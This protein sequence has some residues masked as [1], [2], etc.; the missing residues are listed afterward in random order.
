MKFVQDELRQKNGDLELQM[1]EQGFELRRAQAQLRSL[2]R[3]RAFKKGVVSTSRQREERPPAPRGGGGRGGQGRRGAAAEAPRPGGE[4]TVSRRRPLEAPRA[5]KGSERRRLKGKLEDAA[6]DALVAIHRRSDLTPGTKRHTLAEVLQRMARSQAEAELLGDARRVRESILNASLDGVNCDPPTPPRPSAA[7]GAAGGT[8]GGGRPAPGARDPP[9]S[10]SPSGGG[11]GAAAATTPPRGQAVGGGAA[12]RQALPAPRPP[13]AV[14]EASRDPARR[15][16]R[17]GWN[18]D[19]KAPAPKKE[20]AMEQTERR[21]RLAQKALAAAI[22]AAPPQA[23]RRSRSASPAVASPPPPSDPPSGAER[24]W[25]RPRAAAGAAGATGPAPGRKRPLRRAGPRGEAGG[26][27]W[28]PEPRAGEWR[29][30]TDHQAESDVE[31]AI[32]AAEARLQRFTEGLIA[33]L[34]VHLAAH[35]PHG[36]PGAPAGAAPGLVPGRPSMPP[37]PEP[38]RAVGLAVA[39][40]EHS[41]GRATPPGRHPGPASGVVAAGGGGLRAGAGQAP[42]VVLS[43]AEEPARPPPRLLTLPPDAVERLKDSRDA[44]ARRE[45]ALGAA[46][47]AEVGPDFDAVEVAELMSEAL[48][49]DVL[50]ECAEEIL[51]NLDVYCENLFVNEFLPPGPE[52]EIAVARELSDSGAGGGSASSALWSSCSGEEDSA[53]SSA[54]NTPSGS[55]PGVSSVAAARSPRSVRAPAARVPSAAPPEAP[56]GRPR[57]TAAPPFAPASPRASPPSTPRS[58]PSALSSPLSEGGSIE[59]EIGFSPRP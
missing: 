42:R 10:P 36:P 7:E 29:A 47:S 6:V 19:T 43:G 30:D 1:H 4:V 11:E 48:L 41:A 54:A 51:G 2:M 13:R 20:L 39:S 21:E 23:A 46:L 44:H 28:S 17:K 49:D 55:S 40:A 59:E 56:R 45:R 5:T 37:F 53:S 8:G 52:L 14:R 57:A 26:R 27:G 9:P 34:T 22:A 33:Q 38:H 15:P 3:D 25:T 31:L 18:A 12:P 50:L 58:P 35:F 24:A 32:R 16:K